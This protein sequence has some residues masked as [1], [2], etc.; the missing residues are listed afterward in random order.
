M[1][2]RQFVR[3]T[4]AG[5][6]GV[7]ATG[8]IDELNS[9]GDTKRNRREDSNLGGAETF[10]T[11]EEYLSG[12]TA[13]NP[14]IE[15]VYERQYTQEID[16]HRTTFRMT[17]PRALYEYYDARH[18]LDI[19]N[20]HQG[21]ANPYGQYV[22]DQ[23]Q[24]N[25]VQEVA[26]YFVSYGRENNL[27][28][29]GIIDQVIGFVQQLE[30]TSDRVN[31]GFDNYPQYPFETLVLRS[32]D[33]EDSSIL[34]ASLLK[35]LGY[36][37]I[38][39]LM[40]NDAHMA[41]G[42]KGETLP[43]T[44]YEHRGNRFYYLEA[45]APSRVGEVPSIVEDGRARFLEIRSVPVLV[46]RWAAVPQENSMTVRADIRN[47]GDGPT[48]TAQIQAELFSRSGRVDYATSSTA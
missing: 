35:H 5:G 39:L 34:T 15:G 47:V 43:G 18:R 22:A 9:G 16:G 6:V 45:T 48:D 38:L 30:Y 14:E 4:L 20:I 46:F 17:L 1:N 33:C 12:N 3:A 40:P 29:R 31:N 10:A 2:R 7:S 28:R 11:P 23:Y 13:P 26:E 24:S 25:I 41:V 36:D 42:V 37:V 32:G 21:N 27:S 8:C 19:E 44:Y